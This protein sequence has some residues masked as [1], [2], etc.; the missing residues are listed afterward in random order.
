M[1][2]LL[3]PKVNQENIH[4]PSPRS[5]RADQL[6]FFSVNV[7]IALDIE[8][9]LGIPRDI[10][11]VS[12]AQTYAETAA[13]DI[14]DKVWKPGLSELYTCANNAFGMRWFP[15]LHEYHP[16]TRQGDPLPPWQTETW[17]YY[18]GEKIWM[19]ALFRRFPTLLEG[20]IAHWFLLKTARYAP[21]MR[22]LARA[23]KENPG[24]KL[25]CL[26][27]GPKTSEQDTEHC[28]YSTNPEYGAELCQLIIQFRLFEPR[29]LTWFATGQDPGSQAT[30]D[31]DTGSAA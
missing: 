10:T 8:G 4:N 20:W 26:A 19:P 16:D 11:I 21:A 15:N 25:F 30:K 5:F 7:P 24:W 18:K 13:E 27:L 6:A 31:L 22:A 9:K 12:L 23:T 28:G 17:E 3:L 14:T 29:T 1:R 2:T